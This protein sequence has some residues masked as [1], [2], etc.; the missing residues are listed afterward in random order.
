MFGRVISGVFFF[1]Q[2]NDRHRIAVLLTGRVQRE[3]RRDERNAV[4]H[5]LL[6]PVLR[7]LGVRKLGEIDLVEDL[8]DSTLPQGGQLADGGEW[9]LV[10]CLDEQQGR[11]G[12]AD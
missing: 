4:D 1:D 11:V 6:L 9:D 12:V 7:R 8:A 5:D 2:Q 3:R 10:A